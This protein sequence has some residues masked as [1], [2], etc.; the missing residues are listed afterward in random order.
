MC[1][2]G[3]LALTG[4]TYAADASAPAPFPGKAGTFAD[5]KITV[6]G[7]EREYRLIVPASVDLSKPAPIVFAFHGMGIDNKDHYAAI[8]GLPELAAEHKFILVFPASSAEAIQGQAVKSWALTPEHAAADVLFFDALLAKLKTQYR[9]DPDAIY[10]TGMSN[11]AY[12]AHLL[13]RLRAEVIAAV[14][15]HS[16]ELGMMDLGQIMT[17]RKFPVMII[18]G[19]AD[20]IFDVS[21]ARRAREIYTASRHPVTYLEIPGWGHEWDKRVDENIWDFFAANRL[22][23]SPSVPPTAPTVTSVAK[24]GIPATSSAAKTPPAGTLPAH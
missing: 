22:H 11:G 23:P 7:V 14:A 3:L 16:G 10:V 12:F 2:A 6:G 17:A 8:S 19:D 21:N 1:V 15:A 5:E 18:H 20:Q 13:G 9:L 4:I 24:P